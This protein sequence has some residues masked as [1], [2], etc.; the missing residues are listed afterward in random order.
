MSP[1]VHPRTVADAIGAFAGDA[2]L[3]RLAAI[4]ETC[5][6]PVLCVTHHHVWRDPR[7]TQPDAWFNT[8]ID[9][10]RLAVLLFA[11]RRRDPHNH[12]LVCHGHRH[13]MT[14]GS[15]DDGDASIAVFGMPSS[16]LG[17]K[18]LTGQL[19]GRLRYAI[20]GLRDDGSWG[21]AATE[22]GALTALRSPS[23]ARRPPSPTPELLAY[24]LV[25]DSTTRSA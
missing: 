10:D 25:P 12:V 4:L 22:V 15:I 2:Q 23:R 5:R 20:A 17:D 16:T 24:S 21:V 13:A 19:D 9:A 8:V 18:S 1:S 11:Y 6:G 3:A 7:F 14:A